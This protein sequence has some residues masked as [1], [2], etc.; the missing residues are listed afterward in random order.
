MD[1]FAN[2]WPHDQYQHAQQSYNSYPPASEIQPAGLSVNDACPSAEPETN[3]RP[4]LSNGVP[5][6]AYLHALQSEE[7]QAQ[8]DSH[9]TALIS[10]QA[11]SPSQYNAPPSQIQLP[12]N[13]IGFAGQ[14]YPLP[15]DSATVQQGSNAWY[16]ASQASS[17]TGHA[18]PAFDPDS[19][20]LAAH[21]NNTQAH[22]R[23][24][25]PAS[26]HRGT[27]AGDLMRQQQVGHT[28][29]NG[30]QQNGQ[31]QENSVNALP[32]AFLFGSQ[33]VSSAR[34]RM[35]R[36]SSLAD[37]LSTTPVAVSAHSVVHRPA[38]TLITDEGALDGARSTLAGYDIGNQT[39]Y[40]DPS[41][42]EPETFFAGQPSQAIVSG[43]SQNA[44]EPLS[45]YLFDSTAQTSHRLSS[46][47][48]TDSYGSRS[49]YD[50]RQAAYAAP[51]PADSA[52][53]HPYSSNYGT[54]YQSEHVSENNTSQSASSSLPSS[55][56]LSRQQSSSSFRSPA[57]DYS[58]LQGS[59]PPPSQSYILAANDNT[60]KRDEHPVPELTSINL[61]EKTAAL[62]TWA[63]LPSRP[64]NDAE[65]NDLIR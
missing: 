18:W 5:S 7:Y 43:I 56:E 9:R 40:L 54:R 6:N 35:A 42:I 29:C 44:D 58:Q 12:P 17:V 52:T 37:V 45:S 34:P 23:A 15:E 21:W 65:A 63:R 25:Q 49:M 47:A 33:A 41:T 2:G 13:Y 16:T 19:Q 57:T 8:Y 36:S 28:Q 10:T 38:L 11:N 50:L 31:C 22:Q 30:S 60:A 4:T 64:D 59:L 27:S 61:K 20:V 53:Q 14:S 24:I 48:V 51:S 39:Q 55:P 3:A 62:D 32:P 46:A 1:N 26:M